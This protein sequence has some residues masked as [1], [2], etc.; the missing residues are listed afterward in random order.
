[1][2]RSGKKPDIDLDSRP[3]TT[4]GGIA[5]L[6]GVGRQT[7]YMRLH[8]GTLNL[9]DVPQQV[10]TSGTFYDL[11]SI[12]RRYFPSADGNMVATIMFDFMQENGGMVR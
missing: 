3:K 4:A 9:D 2:R 7:I 10:T 1:M 12:V 5:R 8:D 11:E 6:T